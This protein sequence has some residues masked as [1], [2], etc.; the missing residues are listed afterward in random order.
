M[1]SSGRR[2]PWLPITLPQAPTVPCHALGVGESESEKATWFAVR[3]VFA[4]G[5]SAGPGARVYEERI[6]LWRATSLEDAVARAETEAKTYAASVEEAPDSYLG[7]AQ[8]FQLF[9]E[10]ADGAELFSLMRESELSAEDYLDAFFD[11][12]SERSREFS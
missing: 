3:C 7:L 6:T 12:G 4:S 8:A 5:S 1:W 10:P 9:D 2:Q 11:T